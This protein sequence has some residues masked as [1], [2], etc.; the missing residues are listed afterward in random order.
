M[1]N[2]LMIFD[3]DGV[4]VDLKDTHFLTLNQAITDVVG[5]KHIISLSDHYKKFD[6]LSTYDKLN[7]LSNDKELDKSKHKEINDKKQEYTIDYIISNV[8]PNLNI[9]NLFKYLKENGYKIA[10][11]SNSVRNTIYSV[12]TKLEII[13]YVDFVVSNEDV[14]QRKPNPEIYLKT[15]SYFGIS[16]KNT[17]I[18]EDSPYGIEAAEK[19][20][21]NV[22]RVTDSSDLNI[23]KIK[24]KLEKL[25]KSTKTKWKGD[26]YKVVI[27]MAGLGSRFSQAGYTFPKPLIEVNGKPMI[28]V[29]VE[30]LNIEAEFIFIVQ[31]EH[32]EK[33]NL[34][35]LL[36]LI[37]PN[38]KIV[39]IDGLTD[40]AARTVLKAV[41]FIDNDSHLIIANSDQFI[42]WDSNRFYYSC[43]DEKVDG[44][45]LCFNATHP[46]WSYAK[47]DESGYISEVAE[48]K[49]ISNN[50]TVGVYYFNKGSDFVKSANK[51]IEK[52][53][54]TNNE[55]YVCPVYNEAIE[56]G[57]KIKP[58]MCDKMWGI[59]TPEDL[60]IFL[61]EHK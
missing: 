14:K 31:R 33:Y 47:L 53:I 27:P 15:M 29:V 40:G 55:F 35:Y 17:I 19:S 52:D 30:N 44:G 43:E 24:N 39:Q 5:F 26:N 11:A 1:M 54:R 8:N 34:N 50:A 59:G 46:K 42:E 12:L 10:I 38:C 3:L 4:L 49:Q 16:P 9:T 60:N 22:I 51:M 61:N 13:K 41:D 23:D 7:I 56:N 2:T 57:L 58:Y 32:Y 25:T 28:Q 18:V 48:K 37:A 36:N 6:G 21:G 45:I 20:G